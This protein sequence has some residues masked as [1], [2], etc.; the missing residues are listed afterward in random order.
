MITFIY[1]LIGLIGG[2]LF[3]LIIKRFKYLFIVKP[4]IVYYIEHHS[5]KWKSGNI[6]DIYY[7][8]ENNTYDVRCFFK[9]IKNNKMLLLDFGY[10]QK[11][12]SIC[13]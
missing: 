13:L 5:K 10:A 2:L 3:Y 11:K 8:T 9:E 12:R 7:K 4:S 6:I 1:F